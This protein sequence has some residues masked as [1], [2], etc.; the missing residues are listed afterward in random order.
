MG[1]IDKIQ[2]LVEFCRMKNRLLCSNYIFKDILISLNNNVPVKITPEIIKFISTIVNKNLNISELLK[3]FDKCAIK[4]NTID[5]AH[6]LYKTYNIYKSNDKVFYTI[7]IK[8]LKMFLHKISNNDPRIDIISSIKNL[9]IDYIKYCNTKYLTYIKTLENKLE[10]NKKRINILYIQDIDNEYN[11]NFTNGI[12]ENK[13]I[14]IIKNEKIIYI[15]IDKLA[16]NITECYNKM[17]KEKKMPLKDIIYHLELIINIFNNIKMNEVFLNAQNE[18][19]TSDSDD[20]DIDITDFHKIS[21]PVNKNKKLSPTQNTIFKFSN[22]SNITISPASTTNISSSPSVKVSKIQTKTS[23][24]NGSSIE[25]IKSE[26][27]ST[28]PVPPVP[29]VPPILPSSS[30]SSVPPVPP[31]PP[32]LPVNLISSTNEKNTSGT[33]NQSTMNSLMHE[34]TNSIEKKKDG[35]FFSFFGLKKKKENT[36]LEKKIPK[37]SKS[38]VDIAEILKR[39]RKSVV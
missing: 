16:E 22:S 36:N 25:F 27:L 33:T 28:P 18:S 5:I 4:Y 31:V 26:S 29:P 37:R 2:S 9:Y 35:K 39:D 24:N 11:V 10:K 20:S 8:Y 13:L 30:I 15:K 21:N 6:E 3:L 32:A 1:S 34:L 14:N 23:S 38:G 12:T 7:D 17:Y 19:D